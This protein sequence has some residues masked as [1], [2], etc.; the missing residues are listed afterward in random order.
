MRGEAVA[1]MT[2]GK[3]GIAPT[4]RSSI[5]FGRVSH[6]RSVPQHHSFWYPIFT[7][8]LDVDELPRASLGPRLFGFNRRAIFSVRDSDYLSGEGTLRQKVEHILRERGVSASPA[9]IT[10]ITTPRYFGYVFNPVSFFACFDEQDRLTAFITEV[11]NTFGETHIYPLVCEPTSLPVTWRFPK[12]FFV[13]PFFDVQGGYI[14]SLHKEGRQIS[15]Q[16]DLEKDEKVVFSATLDGDSEPLARSSVWRVIRR[17]P[18]TTF[19]TMPRIHGQAMALFFRV[20]ACPFTKPTPTH[21]YTIRSQQG[22][23]HRARLALL[24]MLKACRRCKEGLGR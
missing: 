10:L 17:Y 13:S 12:E 23:I 24:G 11:N 19:L 22:I 16:V 5:A 14:V 8:Q 2:G 9:R 18:L 6:W 7:F 21:P 20:G 4:S 15:V 1:R 3:G